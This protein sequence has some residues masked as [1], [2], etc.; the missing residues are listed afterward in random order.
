MIN[1]TRE[2]R[3]KHQGY[4]G[5][6]PD[7]VSLVTA[8]P[9]RVLDI[10]C[11]AGITAQLIKAKFPVAEVVGLELEPALAQLASEKLDHLVMG[12][13]E[14]PVAVARLRELGPYDLIICADVLEHLQD[15]W[16]ALGELARLLSLRGQVITSI[17][18]VRHVSTFLSLGLMGRWPRRE[19]GIHDKTHLRFFA[20]RDVLE[21]GQSAGLE[22]LR[23]RRNLRLVESMPWTMLPAKALDFWPLR[24]FL[25]F[26]YLHLWRLR[27][28]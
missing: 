1:L 16:G 2:I 11:G 5:A 10:G 13:V 3:K 22:C 15:P 21:L 27:S 9:A 23:E 25:T 7:V 19:R 24:P 26:Q 8:S 28:A 12:S 14:S 18:N 17:P 6:R 4:S 20:R